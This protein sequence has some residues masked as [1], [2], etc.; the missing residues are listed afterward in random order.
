YYEIDDLIERYRIDPDERIY[1]YG[2]VN[3]G[4]ISGYELEIEYYPFPGWK[5]F[6]NFFSFRGKSKTT[7]NALND[8]PPPRLFMGTRLWIER[9]S[10]EINT[11][12]QQEKKR[13]GPAEIAIPGYG[14]VNIKA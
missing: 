4:Q 5:I 11:T 1:A 3:R 14:A 6:G 12:L 7:Q 10:L 2:N 9:F 13:P 8:I